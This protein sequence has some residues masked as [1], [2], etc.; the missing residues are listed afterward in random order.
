ML[1]ND[2]SLSIHNPILI[3]SFLALYGVLTV[4]ML[5]YVHS[6]FRTASKTLKLLETEWQSAESRHAGFVGA[7]HHQLSKLA[8]APPPPALPA[9]H[10]A[11][12]FDLRN[13]IVAMAKRGIAA[14]EISRSCGLNEGEVEV[15]LGMVRL[16]R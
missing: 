9:R 14:P 4:L 1:A 15:V 5:T 13:Q 11:M 16:Q 12:N 8:V 7:A 6:K 10:T 2:L 3:Y